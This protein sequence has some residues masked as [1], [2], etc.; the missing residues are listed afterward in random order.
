LL[1]S[2][3]FALSLDGARARWFFF[4]RSLCMALVRA[5]GVFFLLVR[6]MALVRALW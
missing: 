5:L 3:F 2:V 6:Y 4:A 1:G